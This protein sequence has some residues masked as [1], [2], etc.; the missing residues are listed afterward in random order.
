M[1]VGASNDTPSYTHSSLHIVWRA[2][3][4]GL[5]HIH[6]QV[7]TS[8]IWVL[9]VSHTKA[10]TSEKCPLKTRLPYNQS[11]AWCRGL[12]TWSKIVCSRLTD[13]PW[14]AMGWHLDSE[15]IVLDSL[16]PVGIL[17]CSCVRVAKNL[18][19]P[20]FS[21]KRCNIQGGPNMQR[22]HGTSNSTR[23]R[24]IYLVMQFCEF[25]RHDK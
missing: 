15:L 4:P 19:Q 13:F 24:T 7:P 21:V 11:V 2:H 16:W 17:T 14:Q 3:P 5:L 25:G 22:G 10:S 6:V 1:Y 9:A 12:P 23:F 8:N 18:Q 20:F